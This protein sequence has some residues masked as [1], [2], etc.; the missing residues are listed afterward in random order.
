VDWGPRVPVRV[1]G[2]GT[3]GQ[4]WAD[5]K[6]RRT[7]QARGTSW[8]P[9]ASADM[10]APRSAERS[11]AE[12]ADTSEHKTRRP[13]EAACTGPPGSNDIAAAAAAA[14]QGLTRVHFSAQREHFLWY[15]GCVEGLF[16]GCKGVCRG[17]VGCVFVS[18]TTQ[19]ELRSG[20]V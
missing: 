4:A 1:P 11:R 7:A 8:V 18:D 2:T 20:R 15:R 5:W 16:R 14:A 9:N 19:D 10:S 13:I 17:R 12:V 6:R 3:S